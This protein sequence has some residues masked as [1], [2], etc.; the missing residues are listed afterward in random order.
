MSLLRRISGVARGPRGRVGLAVVL[1]AL[2]GAGGAVAGG[3]RDVSPPWKAPSGV[4]AL[5]ADAGGAGR[6]VVDPSG[7]PV[8]G[9]DGKP[10]RVAA[11]GR[12]L[13]DSSGAALRDKAGRPI[14]LQPGGT[15]P[16]AARRHVT[17]T[18]T[19]GS[20]GRPRK[21]S[22]PKVRRPRTPVTAASR[23]PIVI[24]SAAIDHEAHNRFYASVGA[25]QRA[26]DWNLAARAVVDW[27][28]ADGG[29]GGRPI[30][31]R[32]EV[33]DPT[34]LE[35]WDVAYEAMCGRFAQGEKPVAVVS[36]L[37]GAASHPCW[38]ARG[39]PVVGSW[40]FWTHSPE[41]AARRGFL[42]GPG[43]I[44]AD[45]VYDELVQTLTDAG[46]LT[47]AS[48]V[49]LLT[50]D[51]EGGA[52][53]RRALHDALARHGI[54]I[55]EEKIFAEDSTVNETGEF[56][57]EAS[58]AALRF[59]LKRIDR[60]LTTL[61]EGVGLF[62]LGAQAHDYQPRYALT[63]QEDPML[64]AASAEGLGMAEQL[65]GALG[66]GWAPLVDV[67]AGD[68]GPANAARAR[69]DAIF[70]A[71]GTPLGTRTAFGQY[72]AYSMC[73][74]LLAL[75][76]ALSRSSDLAA[77][78]E[79]LGD[80]HQSAVTMQ[81]R[82]GPGRHEGAAAYRMFRFGGGRFRYDGPVRPLD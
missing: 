10:L 17:P 11:D 21:R 37:E 2:T 58:G 59:K 19:P 47:R 77:G 8:L 81:T 68:E 74:G 26:E 12:T 69:C 46:W 30:K 76:A 60:V 44:A 22:K 20:R 80:A 1:L 18:P 55:S 48:R 41:L 78:F 7:R 72:A 29:I 73:D 36:P 13:V 6:V 51:G 39:I 54:A 61:G 45:H 25:T 52:P 43:S 75:R 9:K 23:D 66:I 15:L 62:M 50:T 65:E 28:N 4:D 71:A 3:Q 56:T 53:L 79:A 70:R 24:G 57:A 27:I 64:L 67:A 33:Y 49:G 82:L 5:L 34:K 31:L 38:K 14:R 63:S 32:P 40:K 16:A 35:G 42:F